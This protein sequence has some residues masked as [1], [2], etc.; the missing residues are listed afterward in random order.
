M[1]ADEFPDALMIAEESTSWPGVT[2]STAAGGLGFTYKWNL[3]WMHDT[4]DY[5]ALDP[6]YRSHHHDEMTFALLYAY[7]ERFI[8][9]LSHDEVVHGK[10]SLL[11]KMGGDDWQRFAALR[12]LYAWQ[13]SLPGSPLVFMGAELAPWQEWNDESELPWHLLDHRAHRGVFDLIGALN[14]AADAWPALWRRDT[15]PGGFQWL[16]ADDAAHSLYAFVRWD[17]DGATAVVCIANFT[18]VPRPGYRVGPPVGRDLAGDHRHRR[19]RLVGSGHRGAEARTIIGTDEPWQSL[20]PLRRARHRPDV[21]DLVR[22][23]ARRALL[24][25]AESAVRT[26]PP[27]TGLLRLAQRRRVAGAPS[28]SGARSARGPACRPRSRRAARRG[29]TGSRA[30]RTT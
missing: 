29:T 20:G 28:G 27:R 2:A 6:V 10:G 17:V 21:D 18:P 3:G 4:L 16:D 7:N 1:V 8:L 19:C 23:R 5:L 22:G 13:W 9:P 14:A 24:D 30:A 12:A 26:G 25:P 15:D 11:A